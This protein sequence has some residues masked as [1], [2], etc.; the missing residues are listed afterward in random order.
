M[1]KKNVEIRIKSPLCCI[2]HFEY[3]HLESVVFICNVCN[4]EELAK[5]ARYWC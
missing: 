4:V 3:H 1:N 2:V 5:D